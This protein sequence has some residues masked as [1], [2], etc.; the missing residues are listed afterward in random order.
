MR[1]Q[2]YCVALGALAAVGSS[3]KKKKHEVK[4]KK[5]EQKKEEEEQIDHYAGENPEVWFD[6]ETVHKIFAMV[7]KN[8]D[9]KATKA[10]FMAFAQEHRKSTA[11]MEVEAIIHTVDKDKDGK[12][13]E[14][15]IKKHTELE[16]KSHLHQEVEDGD[17]EQKLQDMLIKFSVADLDGNGVL[18]EDEIMHLFA[19]ETHADVMH[20]HAQMEFSFR[21]KDK[22]DKLDMH[23]FFQVLDPDDEHDAVVDYEKD[24]FKQVDTNGDGT[25]DLDEFAHFES[26]KFHTETAIQQLFENADHDKDGSLTEADMNKAG[27]KLGES[28][29]FYELQGWYEHHHVEPMI[30][31]EAGKDEL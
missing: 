11:K 3:D 2:I 16:H 30:R 8:K 1:L 25:L 15:E 20:S 7:D 27:T 23:E 31:E 28:D 5:H 18:E 21:D 4:E 13:S 26:G 10:D 9:G 12:L 24:E 29:A 6:P 19:P 17:N 14:K 22:N